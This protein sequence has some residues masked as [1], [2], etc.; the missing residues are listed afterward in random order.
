MIICTMHV[1]DSRWGVGGGGVGGGSKVLQPGH[2]QNTKKKLL[3]FQVD[4]LG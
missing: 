4:T 3:D 2:K 1:V